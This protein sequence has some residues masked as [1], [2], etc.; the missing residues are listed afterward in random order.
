MLLYATTTSE[1][2]SKGQGGNE[3]LNVGIFITD[4][5]QP[6]YRVIIKPLEDG[7]IITKLESFHFGKWSTKYSDAI[8]TNTPNHL[9]RLE[10]LCR[11]CGRVHKKDTAICR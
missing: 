8:Y 10:Q 7:S 11:H 3:F 6:A 9:A 2:A 5:N 4:K 1:R